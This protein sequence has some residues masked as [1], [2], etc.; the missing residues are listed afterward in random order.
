MKRAVLRNCFKL[1]S[2]SN[3]DWVKRVFITPGL[4]P[5]EQMESRELR[6]RLA[7]VN[8]SGKAYRIKNGLIVRR[9]DT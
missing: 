1:R 5:K 8:G 6:K 7:E 2:K 4:T 3:P 9:E